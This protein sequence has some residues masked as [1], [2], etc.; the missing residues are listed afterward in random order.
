VARH[1][2]GRDEFAGDVDADA[3]P[4]LDAA[5]PEIDA[6]VDEGVSLAFEA[7][8]LELPEEEGA[9]GQRNPAIVSWDP[10]EEEEEQEEE[11]PNPFA[12]F[13]HPPARGGV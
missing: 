1:N 6:P 11:K 8:G 4:E 10:E 2:V 9:A 7:A 3:D 5:D 12:A 13:A